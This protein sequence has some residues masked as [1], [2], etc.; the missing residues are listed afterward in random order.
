M[1]AAAELAHRANPEKA[2]QRPGKLSVKGTGSGGFVLDL[3]G[4]EDAM[5]AEFRRG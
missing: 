2:R 4:G 5:D 3:S 1:S